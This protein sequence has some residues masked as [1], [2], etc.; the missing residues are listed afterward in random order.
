[1]KRPLSGNHVAKE[2][3]K[4]FRNNQI[5]YVCLNTYVIVD[6]KNYPPLVF[7]FK[8]DYVIVYDKNKIENSYSFPCGTI[9]TLFE[10]LLQYR[11]LNAHQLFIVSRAQN[12]QNQKTA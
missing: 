7:Q 9:N 2:L 8:D 12:H 10:K 4:F 3:K 5:K 6:S 11:V 1:M